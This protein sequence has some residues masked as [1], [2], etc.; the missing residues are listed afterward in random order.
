[1]TG[2]PD[3]REEVSRPMQIIKPRIIKPTIIKP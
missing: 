3:A 1:M 2:N